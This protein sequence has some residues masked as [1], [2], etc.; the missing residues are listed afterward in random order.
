MPSR[1]KTAVGENQIFIDD[2][3]AYDLTP[4]TGEVIRRASAMRRAGSAATS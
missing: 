4:K 1:E 2:L 3:A